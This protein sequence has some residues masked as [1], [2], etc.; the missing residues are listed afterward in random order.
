M[1]SLCVVDQS[2][3]AN[4]AKVALGHQ[5]PD[6]LSA[7][8]LLHQTFRGVPSCSG[9]LFERGLVDTCKNPFD[10]RGVSD[11]DDRAA[12][13]C[14]LLIDRDRPRTALRQID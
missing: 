8:K 2:V 3:G 10:S 7:G 4:D 1:S 13:N 11:Q 12:G 6:Q 14:R 5:W 9:D